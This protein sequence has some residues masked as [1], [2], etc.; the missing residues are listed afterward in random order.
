MT[1]EHVSRVGIQS[2]DGAWDPPH[3]W[4][5][6]EWGRRHLAGSGIL[7]QWRVACRHSVSWRRVRPSRQID[8]RRMNGV[9]CDWSQPGPIKGSL[10][11]SGAHSTIRRRNDNMSLWTSEKKEKKEKEEE[12]E[13]DQRRRLRS[14]E[15]DWGSSKKTKEEEE[16]EARRRRLRSKTKKTKE[17]VKSWLTNGQW[18][19]YI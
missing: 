6:G 12:D 1:N 5:L 17:H 4:T 2:R 3:K 19:I 7:D 13:E 11:L 16:E 10:Q 8:F 9:T 14:I 18:E 15:E